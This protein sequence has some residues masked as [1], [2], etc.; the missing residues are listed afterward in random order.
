[1]GVPKSKHARLFYRCALHR[2]DEAK[3]LRKADP[4]TTG[5]VYLAGYSVE[6]ILKALILAAAP[7]GK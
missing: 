7:Q 3:I 2:R 5:A 6:C 1:M 4:R